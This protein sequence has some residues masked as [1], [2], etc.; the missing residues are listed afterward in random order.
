[1]TTGVFIDTATLLRNIVEEANSFQRRSI[2]MS[3]GFEFETSLACFVNLDGDLST[4]CYDQKKTTVCAGLPV[5][6]PSCTK[7]SSF[8]SSSHH[9]SQVYITGDYLPPQSFQNFVTTLDTFFSTLA[10]STPHVS[11]TLRRVTPGVQQHH[12]FSLPTQSLKLNRFFGGLEWIVTYEHPQ[13]VTMKDIYTFLQLHTRQAVMD[14]RCTY[15]QEFLPF[16]VRVVQPSTFPCPYGLYSPSTKSCIFLYGHGFWAETLPKQRRLFQDDYFSMMRW[17]FVPQCT[18]GVCEWKDVYVIVLT[19]CSL[20]YRGISMKVSTTDPFLLTYQMMNVKDTPL[21]SLGKHRTERQYLFLFLYSYF[22]K[23]VRKSRM[24]VLFRWLFS[25]I[26]STVLHVREL[27]TIYD[28]CVSMEETWEPFF[29]HVGKSMADF[30]E[31]FIRVHFSP[32]LRSTEQ[33]QK[34][35]QMTQSMYLTTTKSTQ[36]VFLLEFRGFSRLIPH[37]VMDPSQLRFL[38]FS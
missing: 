4:L 3:I 24:I 8:F 18:V 9:S 36:T 16:P 22:T 1:M 7:S 14:I 37:F 11:F 6:L 2:S 35:Q 12:T 32:S 28:I 33:T 25:D 29:H 13:K 21:S 26:W 23:H 15:E 38:S 19:L 27:S 30:L 20:F 10:S 34:L 5:L 17:E 31:Y